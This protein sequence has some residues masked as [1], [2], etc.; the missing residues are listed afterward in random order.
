MG[1]GCWSARRP[2]C[3]M[4]EGEFDLTECAG[5]AAADVSHAVD[6]LVFEARPAKSHRG[7]L[8]T[9]F[10]AGE[11]VVMLGRVEVAVAIQDD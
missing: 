1:A 5:W 9:T 2:E 11:E 7:G 10:H 3:S 8:A 4:R 6:E